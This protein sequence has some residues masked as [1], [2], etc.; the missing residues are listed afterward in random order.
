VIARALTKVS[1]FLERIKKSAEQFTQAVRWKL[2]LSA[3]F[4]KFLRGR[5]REVPISWL[6]L[7]V[8][9]RF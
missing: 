9:C 6:K 8:N 3:A 4:Q 1:G 5:V 7:L 2:I